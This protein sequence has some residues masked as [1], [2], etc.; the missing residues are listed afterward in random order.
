MTVVD[1]Q[2]HWYPPAFCEAQLSRRSYPLWRRA[3]DGE[4]YVYEPSANESWRYGRDF[5]DF[6]HQ[7]RV[8]DDAGIDT[9][10]AS[11]VIAG[12]VTAFE[13]A[14][15]R[16]MAE[17]LNEELAAKQRA[18]PDRFR[19]LAVLPAQDT[20][21]AIEVLDD[22]IGRLG[23]VGVLLHSNIGGASIAARELWP[24][25]ARIAELGVPLFLHP[26][27]AFAEERVSSYDLEPPLSY[28]FD[29]TVAALSLIVSGAL[30]AHP[31]LKV[32]HPHFGGT[33]PFLVDRVD[34]YRRQ[35]R[36]TLERPVREYLSR[37]WTDTVSESP[38]ALALALELYGLDRILFSS[39]WPY[40]PAR[41]GV[42][43]VHQN[44]DAAAAE[45][46]LSGNVGALFADRSEDA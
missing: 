5:V 28:M 27:R 43:F 21:L 36:W 9:V 41:Q 4:G 23:L 12:D 22:A 20:A 6:E 33:L 14:E 18:H 16:A 13:P 17:L 24:L 2:W 11:S 46:V 44:L 29:T 19:G 30:D 40:F 25:Y 31:D 1:C 3:E 34:V 10:I 8:M 15:G 26:T 32:V 42:D 38:G 45:Q 39:D 35:G 7:L 37:M